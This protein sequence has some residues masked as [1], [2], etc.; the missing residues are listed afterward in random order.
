MPSVEEASASVG[1]NAEQARELT[2]GIT[3]SKDVI[4]G[5]I[6]ALAALGLDGKT[7]HAKA[8]SDRAQ[9]LASHANALADALDTL[10]SH[11]EALKGLLAGAAGGGQIGAGT[12]DSTRPLKG[13]AASTEP[14]RVGKRHL[15][16]Q[17]RIN[18]PAKEKNTVVLPRVDTD[19]DIG[20]IRSGRARH[21]RDNLYEVGDRIYGIETPSGTVYPVRGDGFVEMD[22]LEFTALKGLLAHGGDRA[23]AERDPKVARFQRHMTDETWARA[24]SVFEQG[25]G[26]LDA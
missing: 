20:A 18:S 6:G 7:G 22:R 17:I 2:S 13:P 1:G 23:A 8:A 25:Q 11:I 10:R 14:T 12:G 24:R 9:E 21:V 4:D 16:G 26:D 5:L 19:A 3:A 15:L